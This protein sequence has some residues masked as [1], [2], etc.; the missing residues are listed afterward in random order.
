[1]SEKNYRICLN[2]PLGARNGTMVFHE[3]GGKV[4]GWLYIM[5]EKKPIFRRIFGRRTAYS[6]RCDPHSDQHNSLYSHGYD[7]WTKDSTESENGFRHTV[8]ALWR[9]VKY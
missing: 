8:S 1:M 5:N 2:V 4:D 6:D 9:G 3:T 7:L